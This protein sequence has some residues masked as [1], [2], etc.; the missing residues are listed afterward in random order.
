M[1]VGLRLKHFVSGETEMRMTR[2]KASV[3]VTC[4]PLGAREQFTFARMSDERTQ[5]LTPRWVGADLSVS[6]TV[7]VTATLFKVFNVVKV[8]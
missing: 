2:L 5:A 4:H 1:L 6:G 8:L 7:T 3:E